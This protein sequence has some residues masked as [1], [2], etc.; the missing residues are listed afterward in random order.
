M[1]I[2]FAV[3]F[4]TCL[5]ALIAVGA[6]YGDAAEFYIV[7]GSL[8][9]AFLIGVLILYTVALKLRERLVSER[10]AELEKK[11]SDMPLDEALFNFLD[12][13]NLARYEDN[14]DFVYLKNDKKNFCRK[15][16]G[17]RIK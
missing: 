13:R 6:I 11:F 1:L 9:G 16:F 12:K 10:A 7:L 4:V 2:F 3:W 8:F 14:K 17:F 15:A 5:P